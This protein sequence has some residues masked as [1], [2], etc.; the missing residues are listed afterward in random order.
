MVM[1]SYLY[2]GGLLVCGSSTRGTPAAPVGW[3]MLHIAVPVPAVVAPLQLLHLR[4]L[5]IHAYVSISCFARKA[6]SSS[7]ET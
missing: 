5:H 1:V 6:P 3:C 2:S 7:A 4:R